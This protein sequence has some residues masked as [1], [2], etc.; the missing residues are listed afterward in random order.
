[1]TKTK[2]Q[3]NKELTE[4]KTRFLDVNNAYGVEYQPLRKVY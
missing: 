4:L 1:M 3:L 2:E